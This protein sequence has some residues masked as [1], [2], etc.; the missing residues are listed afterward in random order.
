VFI[1][2]QFVKESYTN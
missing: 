1:D 2:K